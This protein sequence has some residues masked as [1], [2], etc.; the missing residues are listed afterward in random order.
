MNPG[1]GTRPGFLHDPPQGERGYAL[2]S[3]EESGAQTNELGGYYFVVY[4]GDELIASGGLDAAEEPEETRHLVSLFD[5]ATA[6]A[7]VID[8]TSEVATLRKLR[9]DPWAEQ[10][11]ESPGSAPTAQLLQHVFGYVA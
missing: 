7:G 3:D 5:L 6:S 8:W 1:G 9:D 11:K 4:R 10:A 2:D